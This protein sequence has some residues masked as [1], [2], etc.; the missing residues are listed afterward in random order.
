MSQENESEKG[1][2]TQKPQSL[3]NE[4]ANRALSFGEKA[5]GLTF[6]PSGDDKVG[7]AKQMMANVI[8]LLEQDHQE[9]VTN[10]TGGGVPSSSWVR[11][12]LRTAAFN[13]V[14]TAQMAVVKYLTW[15]D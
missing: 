7:Q 2:I 9:K 10:N 14:V 13:A 12:V 1:A 4:H 11:N 3:P 5:V 15:K 8:D 6:N